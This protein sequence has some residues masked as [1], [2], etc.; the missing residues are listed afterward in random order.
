MCIT[1]HGSRDVKYTFIDLS[2][3]VG[4]EVT[5]NFS[6]HGYGPLEINHYIF[7]IYS[8]LPGFLLSV[9]NSVLKK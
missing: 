5:C 6:V 1:I 4:F 9:N 7:K 2:A 8:S 3:Y